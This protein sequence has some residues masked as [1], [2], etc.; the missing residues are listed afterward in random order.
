MTQEWLN[1]MQKFYADALR[2][3]CQPFDFSEGHQSFA[4]TM[5]K[6]GQVWAS[7][8]Q[9]STAGGKNQAY[10]GFDLL[11]AHMLPGLGYTREKQEQ[12]NDL[13]RLWIDFRHKT[14]AYDAGMA[15]IGLEAVKKFQDWLSN[16]PEGHEPVTTLKGVYAKWI[17]ACEDIYAQYAMSEEY[18]RLYGES[19]NA[20]MSLKKQQ[21]ALM[22][23]IADQFNL[24]SRQEVDSLHKQMHALKR[25][26]AGLK[27]PKAAQP[28]VSKKGK[29]K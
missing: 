18:S 25:E 16:P 9:S 10:A 15:K 12:M 13:F 5:N 19:V 11:H 2:G 24:P 17:D 28:A 22:D 14:N 3:S 6:A 26:L 21:N 7:F 27:K 4:H 23:D 20:L 29:K 8:L 1:Q